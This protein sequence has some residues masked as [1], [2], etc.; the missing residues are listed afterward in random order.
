M[1]EW[2]GQSVKEVKRW[3]VISDLVAE[4]GW[5][6]GVEV[7][8]KEGENLFFIAAQCPDLKITGVD[9]WE[10]QLSEKEGENYASWNMGSKY[11]GVV[12]K[13]KDYPNVTITRDYSVHAAK[14]FEDGSLD[15]VF[16]DAQH[17][18]DCLKADVAA[19][20]SKVK[21]D[22]VLMGHDIHFPGVLKAVKEVFPDYIE[23][24]NKIWMRP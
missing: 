14:Q 4:K 17:T 10:Q 15:F 19:W 6:V 7:G 13:A 3:H 11:D 20:E 24:E 8:V 9:A 12:N 1:P 23:L 16:I 21:S 22:G 18:Y 5:K 2:R